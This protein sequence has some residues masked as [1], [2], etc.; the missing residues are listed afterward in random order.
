MATSIFQA[1]YN[2]EGKKNV[3]FEN[4]AKMI[5]NRAKK[6]QVEINDYSTN[7]FEQFKKN[8]DNDTTFYRNGETKI[9]VKL[10]FR[11]ITTI[12]KVEDIEEFLDKFKDHYKFFIITKIA[13][14][15]YKQLL[16]YNNVEVF[17]DEDLLVNKIDHMFVPKHI[18]LP[19]EV[20]EQ[21]RQE[22]GFKRNEIGKIKESDPIAR[23]YNL[24]PGDVIEIERPSKI[25]G[26]SIY[27]RVCISAPL[28]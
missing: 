20:Q 9:A 1:E 16:E 24:K 21:I 4:T 18:T 12:R 27:Y 25:S 10:L 28:M 8:Y 11:K 26:I 2:E 7:I 6:E 19:K 13:P 3:I 22:Y 14:K 17:S 15:A 23:Y 5:A